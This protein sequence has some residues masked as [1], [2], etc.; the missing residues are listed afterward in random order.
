M[1]GAVPGVAERAIPSAVQGASSAIPAAVESGAQRLIPLPAAAAAQG[2]SANRSP[3]KGEDL[4][5]QQGASKLG[6]QDASGLMN[7][8]KAKQLL[9]QAS[10]LTPGSKAMKRI[11]DQLRQRGNR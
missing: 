8:P 5:A 2:P 7:D 11:Q 6:I 10:D 3:A 4:W 1:V 9:I